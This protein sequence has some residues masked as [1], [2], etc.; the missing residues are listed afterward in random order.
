[1][2]RTQIIV[3]GAILAAGLAIATVGA[4]D[5]GAAVPHLTAAEFEES[6]S[7]GKVG[8]L[9]ACGHCRRLAPTWAELAAAYKGSDRVA[10]ASVDCTKEAELCTKYEVRGYPTLKLFHG[11]EAKEQYKGPRALDSLKEF[12]DKQA[13]TLLDE[14]DA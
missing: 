3:T 10:I 4:S 12:V 9:L 14:T 1:M 5:A 8:E 11:G 7:D 2:R 13:R 6:I